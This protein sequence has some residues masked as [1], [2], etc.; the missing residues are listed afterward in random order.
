MLSY[1]CEV[2]V[3]NKYFSPIAF[4]IICNQR[5]SGSRIRPEERK[6][7]ARGH[8]AGLDGPVDIPSQTL[9]TE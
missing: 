6:L 8:Y 3:S 4:C 9:D 1:Y 2:L 7:P 5:R